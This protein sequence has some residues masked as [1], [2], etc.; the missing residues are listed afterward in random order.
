MS[1]SA[2]TLLVL[3]VV[4]LLLLA[5]IKDA[6]RINARIE[7]L[8]MHPSRL[9]F[10][11]L[12]ERL[13]IVLHHRNKDL[14][15]DIEGILSTRFKHTYWQYT[16]AIL[17]SNNSF[18][19]VDSRFLILMCDLASSDPHNSLKIS[20]S[21]SDNG[22]S[23]DNVVTVKLSAFRNNCIILPM[24]W[25]WN[26]GTNAFVAYVVHDIYSLMRSKWTSSS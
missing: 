13:P 20:P 10:E 25:S 4:M 2:R 23:D 9:S 3:A 16:R 1:A 7:I 19:K 6:N 5:Y 14:S 18:K 12:R 17:H 26:G 24:Y 21:N 22:E 8:Q 15:L 11:T